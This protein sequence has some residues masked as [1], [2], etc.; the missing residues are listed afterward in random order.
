[1][2]DPYGDA[3]ASRYDNPVASR[4]W[5]LELLEEAGR[6]PRLRRDGVAYSDHRVESRGLV[7]L[8]CRR[9]VVT[10]RS[11]QIG[12]DVMCWWIV[13]DW[14]LAALPL[15]AMGLDFLSRMTMGIRSICMIGKCEKY[16]MAIV[17]WL[18]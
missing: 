5:L 4:R 8:D 15:I 2:S 17:F 14:C 1:M 7:C 11:L 18:P 9:C 16:F 6:S 12:L 3:E 13:L 10:V